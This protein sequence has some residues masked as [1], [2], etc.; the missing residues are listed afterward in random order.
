MKYVILN[1]ILYF[2]IYK[3]IISIKTYILYNIN[4]NFKKYKNYEINVERKI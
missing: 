3:Y 1:I 4:K 2:Q